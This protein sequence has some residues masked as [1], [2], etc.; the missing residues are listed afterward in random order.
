MITMEEQK[1]Y[2]DITTV[3]LAH[4]F[5]CPYYSPKGMSISNISTLPIKCGA[6]DIQHNPKDCNGECWYM[7]HFRELLEDLQK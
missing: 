5:T 1:N 7:R 6:S 2:I 4:K 3:I